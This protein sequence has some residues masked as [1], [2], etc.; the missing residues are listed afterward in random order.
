MC[1][2]H[3]WRGA[4]RVSGDGMALEGSDCNRWWVA[5]GGW[6]DGTESQRMAQEGVTRTID[7]VEM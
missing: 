2:G 7:W 4:C 6:R 1:G 3:Q 5:R